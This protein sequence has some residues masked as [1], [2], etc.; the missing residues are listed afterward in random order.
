MSCT[1]GAK[2]SG[3]ANAYSEASMRS[4][5]DYTC[6]CVYRRPAITLLQLKALRPC[7]TEVPD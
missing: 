6:F 5:G 4:K 3:M 7:A 2:L 1:R